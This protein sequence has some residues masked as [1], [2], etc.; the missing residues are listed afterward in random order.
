MTRTS[1]ACLSIAVRKRDGCKVQPKGEYEM[2]YVVSAMYMNSILYVNLPKFF[3]TKKE[4]VNYCIDSAIR[5]YDCGSSEDLKEFCVM[6]LNGDA[7]FDIR[8]NDF[9]GC[10]VTYRVRDMKSNLLKKLTDVVGRKSLWKS[11]LKGGD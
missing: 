11:G 5:V 4:A 2:K 9:K 1:L 7:S 8:F 10:Q 3:K 6:E